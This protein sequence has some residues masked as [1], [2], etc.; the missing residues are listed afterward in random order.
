M[1]DQIRR[2][3]KRIGRTAAEQEQREAMI[4]L[5]IW[6]MY[7][8]NVLTLTESDRIDEITEEMQ[9]DSPTPPRQ[10]LNVSVARVREANDNPSK[11]DDLLQDI[12]NR[13]GSR[14]MRLQTY[15]ACKELAQVD[16]Q[17]ADQE[18]RFLTWVEEHFRIEDRG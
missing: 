11:A 10:Y 18:T 13:L 15:E 8:D 3:F 9:W 2:L 1:L 7:A 14:E 16:G 5:L 4:D 17:V 6:T 12:S